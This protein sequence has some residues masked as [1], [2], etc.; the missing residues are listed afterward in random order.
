MWNCRCGTRGLQTYSSQNPYPWCLEEPELEAVTSGLNLRLSSLEVTTPPAELPS[1]RGWWQSGS[2]SEFE[3]LIFKKVSR[4]RKMDCKNIVMWRLNYWP[5]KSLSYY[6]PVH[7]L[8]LGAEW[9]GISVGVHV[10]SFAGLQGAAASW[11][12]RSVRNKRHVENTVSPSLK[13]WGK[14]TG[15]LKWTFVKKHKFFGNHAP[16]L[17]KLRL[18]KDPQNRKITGAMIFLLKGFP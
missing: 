10:Y 15:P 13:P 2:L 4:N 16:I 12:K 7:T 6:F 5:K 3:F 18:L 14:E 9:V 1:C 11:V 8:H 17:K